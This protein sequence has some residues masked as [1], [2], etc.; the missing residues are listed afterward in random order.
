MFL[1]DL[2]HETLRANIT[3][4]TIGF[5]AV[6]F[7]AFI[8]ALIIAENRPG[9]LSP[10]LIW[11][12]AIAARLILLLTT[13]TLSDDVYRYLWDGHVAANGVS[14]YA[15]PIDSAELD[16][17]DVPVRGLANNTWM[18]SPYMPAAQWVFYALNWVAGTNVISLQIAM[19][20]FELGA[21]FF[22]SK[23][24]AAASF[25]SHRI[26][27]WLWNP[28]VI[29]EVAHSA[30]IDGW[31]VFLMMAAVWY[32]FRPSLLAE[33]GSG[34]SSYAWISVVLMAFATLTKVLP[35]LILPAFFWRW[36]WWQ[37]IGYGL[38][39]LA[40]L[41]PAGTRAGWGL[42]G[43]LDG[44][45]LFGAIRIYNDQW[46][47]NSGLFF[48]ATRWLNDGDGYTPSPA[49][50]QIKLVVAGIM[51]FVLLLTWWMAYRNQDLKSSLRLMAVPLI[52]YILLTHT[53]HPW[54][55]LIL[56]IFLPFLAPS[57]DEHKN[58][59]L[60][61]APWI[62]LSGAIILSYMTYFDPN[63]FREFAWVRNWEWIPTL[64]LFAISILFSASR[65]RAK[66]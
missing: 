31:M 47:F 40:L 54:Y 30:H 21:A 38:L 29:V 11:G 14:P 64:T 12:T 6:A 25:P 51:V 17:L 52:A 10:R 9:F 55:F 37:R 5:Y 20:T 45:G 59:W 32:T 7:L 62:Y 15:L 57:I 42:F 18:A 44:T 13:P 8:G 49:D 46:K 58:H 27:L 36:N 39:T 26:L 28:L 53:V 66:A 1:L 43:P 33:D 35:V 34:Q 60:I 61:T 19:I 56:L 50:G 23:L 3:P 22:V 41:I 24:L 63:D 16:F 2:Q 65:V 4:T 48:W